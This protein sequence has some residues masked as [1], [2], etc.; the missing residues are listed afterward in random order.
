MLQG[1]TLLSTEMIRTVLLALLAA[2]LSFATPTWVK[3]ATRSFASCRT[4][5]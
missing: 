2:A 3:R 5:I 1:I 4:P